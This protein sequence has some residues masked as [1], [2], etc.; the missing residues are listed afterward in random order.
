VFDA[1]TPPS[2]PSESPGR[3]GPRRAHLLR[4][5]RGAS[6]GQRP[7][8]P[9]SSPPKTA[10]SPVPAAHQPPRSPAQHP[11]RPRASD[12][13][14]RLYLVM[15]NVSSAFFLISA[16]V[17]GVH[18]HVH[19]QFAAAIRLRYTHPTYR[20]TSASPGGTAGM[21]AVAGT[22]FAAVA[23]PSSWPS[24]RHPSCLSQPQFISRS[25]RPERLVHGLPLLI[26]RLR[27]PAG[28]PAQH[29][30]LRAGRHRPGT[31]NSSP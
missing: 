19:A 16:L 3:T 6:P 20:A 25:S 27:R 9:C 12:R 15:K 1:F 30:Q 26:H 21:W 22:G 17:V 29:H 2:Q 31:G 8:R 11:A 13:D 10:P 7:S 24:S 4:T 23:S 28:E 14:L 5:P 18:H